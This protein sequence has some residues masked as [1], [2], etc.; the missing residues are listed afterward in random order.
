MKVLTVIQPWATLL[1]IGAKKF[2]TRSWS[3]WHKGPILIHAGKNCDPKYAALMLQEPFKSTLA[4]YGFLKPSD[5]PFGAII[6]HGRLK[7][8]NPTEAVRRRID[9]REKAFGFYGD[10]RHAWEFVD[11]RRLAEPIKISGQQ[12]LWDFDLTRIPPLQFLDEHGDIERR[13]SHALDRSLTRLERT[14]D[15]AEGARS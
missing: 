3:C 15:R 8:T 2:E 12:G 13:G 9:A 6:A 14:L 10:G 11:V 4:R 1:A 5:L 7:S